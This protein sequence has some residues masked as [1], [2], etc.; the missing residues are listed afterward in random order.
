MKYMK[1]EAIK[2]VT[3]M[4]SLWFYVDMLCFV[5]IK[6]SHSKDCEKSDW[7]GVGFIFLKVETNL[8]W[9]VIVNLNFFRQLSIYFST[10]LS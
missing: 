5:N 4:I 7:L 9:N 2:Q 8:W 6:M 10:N 3:S 1:L